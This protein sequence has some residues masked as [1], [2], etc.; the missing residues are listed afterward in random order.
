MSKR[1][2]LT[3]VYE[4]V[5]L[6]RHCL[7]R[8]LNTGYDALGNQTRSELLKADKSVAEVMRLVCNAKKRYCKG[9]ATNDD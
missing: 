6:A 9:G 4:L 1:E 5:G 2:Q 7:M 3:V 8:I